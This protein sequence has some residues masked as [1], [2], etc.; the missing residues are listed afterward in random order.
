MNPYFKAYLK[1]A[2]VGGF[3]G[4]TFG[5]ACGSGAGVVGMSQICSGNLAQ[6][7]CHELFDMLSQRN[8]GAE[9][10]MGAVVGAGIGALIGITVYPAYQ[11]IVG[12]CYPRVS[13]ESTQNDL[14]L[15]ESRVGLSV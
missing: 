2:A 4:A 8:Q 1:N 7:A 10:S 6:H 11:G 14:P 13:R 9:A 3:A 5:V 15:N 12:W